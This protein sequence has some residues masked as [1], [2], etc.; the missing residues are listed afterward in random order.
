MNILLGWVLTWQC[1]WERGYKLTHIDTRSKLTHVPNYCEKSHP[2]AVRPSIG[3]FARGEPRAVRRGRAA[4]DLT[5]PERPLS[6]ERRKFPSQSPYN[7]RLGRNIPVPAHA[8]AQG[9]T[10][11][12]YV[13][14]MEEE[15]SALT[16]RR[17][18][19]PRETD[20]LLGACLHRPC[21]TAIVPP[22]WI[23]ELLWRCRRRKEWRRRYCFM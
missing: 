6:S 3:R 20:P 19:W 23:W 4:A 1:S 12:R 10:H 2:T 22:S 16:W 17:Q 5:P 8:T 21:S 13:Q 9:S 15:I 18:R 11:H 7:P 14:R